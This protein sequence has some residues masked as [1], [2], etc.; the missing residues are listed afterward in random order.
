MRNSQNKEEVLAIWNARAIFFYLKKKRA[1]QTNPLGLMV[2]LGLNAAV[3][4]VTSAT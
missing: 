2:H 1:D 4:T 3:I